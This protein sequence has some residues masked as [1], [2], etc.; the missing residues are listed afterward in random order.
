MR[1]LVKPFG[2]DRN[3]PFSRYGAANKRRNAAMVDSDD[4]NDSPMFGQARFGANRG[5]F[6]RSKSPIR[7]PMSNHVNDDE[8]EWTRSPIRK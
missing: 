8:E 7:P 4:D 5:G 2:A 1:T 3:T 6:S